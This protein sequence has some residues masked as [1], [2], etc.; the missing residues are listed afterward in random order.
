M[1]LEDV[2]KS[3]EL[4]WG[5]HKG[6]KLLGLLYTCSTERC[7]AIG[8]IESYMRTFK[9]MGNAEPA[10]VAKVFNRRFKTH[11]ATI[12]LVNRANKC[13]FKTFGKLA[14]HATH[15]GRQPFRDIKVEA[16]ETGIMIYYWLS[17]GLYI[18]HI[19][20]IRLGE[21]AIRCEMMPDEVR[22]VIK[23]NNF[24]KRKRK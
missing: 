22:R 1:L 15:F 7:W 21:F 16:G 23:E 11:P 3:S 18:Q 12:A 4:I 13:L 8:Q 2:P 6:S 5:A 10:V 20:A 14:A 24:P 17:T 9:E 19:P